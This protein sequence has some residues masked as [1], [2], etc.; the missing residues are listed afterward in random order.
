[1]INSA[2]MKWP[3]KKHR[4]VLRGLDGIR[5]STEKKQIFQASEAPSKV[6]SKMSFTSSYSFVWALFQLLSLFRISVEV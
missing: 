3:A 2:N 1:M 6:G 5:H 4:A